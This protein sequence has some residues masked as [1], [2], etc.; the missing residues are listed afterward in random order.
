[1]SAPSTDEPG[2]KAYETARKCVPAPHYDI[3][4]LNPRIMRM[5]IDL[6][7][8]EP[9]VMAADFPQLMSV[10]NPIDF[11]ESVPSLSTRELILGRNAERLP[12]IGSLQQGK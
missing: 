4:V 6:V 5:L 8:I 10:K 9:V 1:L 12:K 2:D 11:V 7:G 3:I